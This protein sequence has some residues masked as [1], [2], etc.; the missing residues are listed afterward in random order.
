MA[1]NE[2]RIQLSFSLFANGNSPN[3]GL[4]KYLEQ[5]DKGESRQQILE[6]LTAFWSP[7][8]AKASGKKGKPLRHLVTDCLYRLKIQEMELMSQFAI[9]PELMEIRPL[10]TVADREPISFSFVCRL[11]N[12]THLPL[13]NYLHS[14]K[15]IFQI[16]QRVLWSCQ[17]F[18]GAIAEQQLEGAQ[19]QQL[20]LIATN[21]VCY[22]R[23]HIAYLKN[24]FQ[25]CDISDVLAS[26]QTS[27]Q[28]VSSL[29]TPILPPPEVE[30]KSQENEAE[31]PKMTA[32]EMDQWL[33]H[34]PVNDEWR[35]N[36]FN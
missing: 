3:W 14:G 26:H 2:T 25:Y 34:D 13:V 19:S 32:E 31:Q 17:A 21:S 30:D 28:R 1:E 16:S 10:Q 36:L 8:A 24:Y 11:Y 29:S 27:T 5:L 15:E 9:E 4:I 22:L 20:S 7:F 23:Q 35:R 18:W 6:A 12:P 33:R